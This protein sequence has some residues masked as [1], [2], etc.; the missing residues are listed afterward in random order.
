MMKLGI[1]VIKEATGFLNPGQIPVIVCDQLLFAIA[2][3]VQWNWPA[4][5]E[6]NIH[7]VGPY[8]LRWFCGPCAVTFF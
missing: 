5:H 2:K 7:A 4:T 1:F 8:T 3:V 6:E